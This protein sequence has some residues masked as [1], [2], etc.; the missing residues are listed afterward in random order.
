MCHQCREL[1]VGRV[2]ERQEIW[3]MRCRVTPLLESLKELSSGSDMVSEQVGK[4]SEIW[5]VFETRSDRSGDTEDDQVSKRKGRSEIWDVMTGSLPEVDQLEA[6]VSLT[7]LLPDLLDKLN[8]LRYHYMKVFQYYYLDGLIEK[9]VESR[10]AD[11]RARYKDR[12]PPLLT[13]KLAKQRWIDQEG[14]C[15]LC[16]E[17]MF[18]WVLMYGKYS[19]PQIDRIDIE[20]GTYVDNFQWLCR[21]CN[22]AKGFETEMRRYD[23]LLVATLENSIEAFGRGDVGHVQT[24]LRTEIDRQCSGQ[25]YV[26]Y[27]RQ[28]C[29][30]TL[31]RIGGEQQLA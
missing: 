22:T 12:P 28:S 6:G 15:A 23:E 14:C 5:E 1:D 4:L 31:P 21:S 26:Q 27:R 11:I 29:D 18:W 10:N 8:R 24:I 19:T 16:K 13:L 25:K 17:G 2:A 7:G 30:R 3:D 9:S 20:I